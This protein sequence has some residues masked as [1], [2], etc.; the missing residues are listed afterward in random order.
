MHN[1]VK[2]ILTFIFMF[3]MGT[4]LFSCGKDG[5]PGPAGVAGVP[6]IDGK[7]GL[8]GTDGSDG[9]D[10]NSAVTGMLSL[11]VDRSAIPWNVNNKTTMP[12]KA[13]VNL[14]TTFTIPSMSK[15][16]NGGWFDFILG[17]QVFCY[18]GRFNTREFQFSYKKLPG[19]GT[20][21][22]QNNDK[23]QGVVSLVVLVQSGETVQIIPR[24]PRYDVV[25][26]FEFPYIG[27]E[28]E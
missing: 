21:C 27:V 23:F 9:K 28:N 5:V 14:P 15:K 26:T 12:I 18:Q 4:F 25:E 17:N 11:T 8:D 16:D 3:L 2:L 19:A 13:V 10:G 7:D 20:G 22:D 1:V 6:G 24:A